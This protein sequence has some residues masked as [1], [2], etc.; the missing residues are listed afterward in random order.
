[1]L[2]MRLVFLNLFLWSL[3]YLQAAPKDTLY[4][5]RFVSEADKSPMSFVRLK[6]MSSGIII[7]SWEAGVDGFIS[8]SKKAIRRDPYALL[9]LDYPGF[10]SK[11]FNPD[12]LSLNDTTIIALRQKPAQI[13][14]IQIIAYIVPMIPE[15][16]KS[17]GRH[18]KQTEEEPERLPV[19]SVEQCLAYEAL[20]KGLWH[21]KDTSTWTSI[22]AWDTLNSHYK[23]KG[24]SSLYL[25]LQYYLMN[26]MA[27]PKQAMDFLMQETVY[28]CFELNEKG[29]VEYLQVM[30]GS[31]VDLVL[32]VA[33]ALARMP[34]IPMRSIFPDYQESYAR[35]RLRP[36]RFMLPVKFVLK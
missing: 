9:T 18:Q 24:G 33:N 29:D 17:W 7:A 34:R 19:Y 14:E 20:K 32:E 16:P 1:M 28:L 30:K 6:A 31:H 23:D 11:T 10:E 5:I 36:V 15:E 13:D 35:S 26:N 25:M 12:A 21:S 27:Y 8:I 4:P 22:L 3:S 2:K